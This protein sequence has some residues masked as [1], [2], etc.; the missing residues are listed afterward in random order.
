MDANIRLQL[1]K[2]SKMSPEQRTRFAGATRQ[3]RTVQL[4]V[5]DIDDAFKD[6]EQR[7]ELPQLVMEEIKSK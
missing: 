5:S 2:G 6:Y 3:K 7:G 1:I 4:Q